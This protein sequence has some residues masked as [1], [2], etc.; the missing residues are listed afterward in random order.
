[1]DELLRDFLTESFENLD[2]VDREI[3]QF[4]RNPDNK[5]ALDKIFRLV[6]TIKGTCGFVGLDRLQRLTHAA[7]GLLGHFRDGSLAVTAGAV[8]LVLKSIDR[9][10]SILL[11]IE[12]S[13]AEPAGDDGD[14]ISALELAAK[15]EPAAQ[16]SPADA[17]PADN[18]ADQQAAL[19]ESSIASQSIRVDVGVLERMMTLVSELVLT[20]NQLMQMVRKSENADFKVPFQRLSTITSDLQDS[21]MR[22]RMQPIGN[23]WSKLPRLVRDLSAEL[24]KKIELEMIGAET[25]L[26]RQVLELIKDPLVHMI[27][28]SADH[29]LEAPKERRAA[30]K[31]EQGRIRL[32]ATHE[33]G[34]I[35]IEVADDGK[36]LNTQRI[37]E[38]IIR[39]GLASENE[40]AALSEQQLYQFVFHPGFSTA[41]KVTELSGRGVGLD[42]VRSNIEAIGGTI[43]LSSVHGAGARFTIKIPLTL[44][45]ISALIVETAGQRYAVPQVSVTELVRARPRSDCVIERIH[46]TPILRLRNELLPLLRLDEVLGVSQVAERDDAF[47][48]ICAVGDRRYGLIVD[49]IFDTEE[50]VVKPVATVLRHIDIY[51]GSTI[52]GDG[53]VVMIVDPHAMTA[54]IENETVDQ[55]AIRD[56]DGAK[57]AVSDGKISLLIFR[58]GGGKQKA[59]PLSHITRLEDVETDRI[60]SCDGLS[61][62]QYRG[63]LMPILRLGDSSQDLRNKSR[64]PILVVADQT[65]A[66]GL[67]VDQILDIVQ[68]RLDIEIKSPR[69]GMLGSAVINGRATEIVDIDHYVS[70]VRHDR[71]LAAL[72]GASRKLKGEAA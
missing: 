19:V 12:E 41:E 64:H 35:V 13:G 43:A 61:L 62:L 50:I 48:V 25:E 45:I 36:G 52:L 57:E 26:D 67:A 17:Q 24:G 3:V 22:M 18:A 14:L 31:P 44:T 29:G 56:D 65:S 51:C 49:R 7:E 11:A 60:E 59:V 71:M 15:G 54:G 4:E 46:A 10:K 47:V 23:A 38:Q 55:K 58:A 40:A 30:G 63:R 20:R 33:G 68:D 53:S 32:S 42:V 28:N 72:E 1:M 34:Y 37:R 8:S 6:H 9:V 16:A 70:S 2:V 5:V 27:R 69:E 66:V 39:R 21:V